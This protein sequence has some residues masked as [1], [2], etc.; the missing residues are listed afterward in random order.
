MSYSACTKIDFLKSCSFQILLEQE[1]R[2]IEFMVQEASLPGWN[3]GELSVP[4]MAQIERRPGDN[5]SW[6]VLNLQV[7]VDE[8]LNVIKEAHKYCFRIKNPEL[9]IIGGPEEVFDGKLLILTNKN[10]YQI[11]I[12]FHDAWISSVGDVNFSHTTPE[13]DPL[14][15]PI[16]ITYNYYTIS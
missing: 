3:I 9:G 2:T 13:D 5:I 12:T 1:E 7:L 4:N 10:N 16:D 6:N 8:K 11:E 14:I 15:V